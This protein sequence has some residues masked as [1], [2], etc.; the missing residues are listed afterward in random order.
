MEKLIKKGLKN[1]VLGF[2]ACPKNGF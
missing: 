1:E 2:F